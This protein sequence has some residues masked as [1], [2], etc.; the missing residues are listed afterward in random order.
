MRDDGVN[1]TIFKKYRNTTVHTKE[2][3]FYYIQ[4]AKIYQSHTV[5]NTIFID[6]NTDEIYMVYLPIKNEKLG[7]NI[8][9]LKKCIIS[10]LK[11]LNSLPKAFVCPSCYNKITQTRWLQQQTFIML[12][13]CKT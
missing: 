1:K 8:E 6:K 10:L 9:G 7:S 2:Q 4:V 3:L 13:C 12:L 11:D 5:A